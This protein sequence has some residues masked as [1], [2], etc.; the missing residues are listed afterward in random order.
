MFYGK[1]KITLL[2]IFHKPKF[3]SDMHENKH[4]GVFS[5]IFMG[6]IFARCNG[7]VT[8]QKLWENIQIHIPII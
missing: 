4:G 2:C 1:P 8:K 7:C 6:T 3:A 5:S